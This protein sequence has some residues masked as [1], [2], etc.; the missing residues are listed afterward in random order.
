MCL[1]QKEIVKP[2]A[3]I[4]KLSGLGKGGVRFV[5]RTFRNQ[6]DSSANRVNAP[7]GTLHAEHIRPTSG[8]A[9]LKVHLRHHS[10]RF[11]DSIE[12]QAGAD[13]G[14]CDD[15]GGAFGFTSRREGGLQA[16]KDE[17][18]TDKGS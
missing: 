10:L 11:Q 5:A 1:A 3:A 16:H 6:P 18:R 8:L 4:A 12:E 14:Q 2:Q 13:D 7:M 15:G 17:G 9:T